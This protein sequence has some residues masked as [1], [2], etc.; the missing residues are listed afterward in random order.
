[1][2]GANNK[3]P[4]PVRYRYRYGTGTGTVPVQVRYRFVFN[5][6]HEYGIEYISPFHRF[7]L[8][9]KE[10]LWHRA[11]QLG[12]TVNINKSD[13][14]IISLPVSNFPYCRRRLEKKA[15]AKVVASVWGAEIIQFLAALAVL[16]RSI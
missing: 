10:P 14:L 6:M 7:R 12:E 4:V 5:L 3:V 8:I 2:T 9:K 16:L 15:K 1:M 11:S 13:T